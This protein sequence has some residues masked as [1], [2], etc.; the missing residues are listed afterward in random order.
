[1]SPQEFD[2]WHPGS[3]FV[4]TL[5]R[6]LLSLVNSEINMRHE[7]R[8]PM[9]PLKKMLRAALAVPQTGQRAD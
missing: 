7:A 9:P 4:L 1:M 8:N 6:D 2:S 5:R 3:K